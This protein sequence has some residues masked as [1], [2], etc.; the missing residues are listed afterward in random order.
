MTRYVIGPD[1]AIRLAHDE[2]VI[3]DERQILAPTL[4]RSQMLSLLYPG[5][6][7]WRRPFGGSAAGVLVVT[8]GAGGALGRAVYQQA[9]IRPPF[10]FKAD[11]GRAHGDVRM[12]DWRGSG[13]GRFAC[14]LGRLGRSASVNPVALPEG[15]NRCSR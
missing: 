9:A 13:R 15:V 8:P 12:A 11:G 5:S 10:R 6:T 4:L 3:R 1:V 2:A 7:P 14:G